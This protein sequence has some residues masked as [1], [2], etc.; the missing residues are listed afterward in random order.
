MKK[1]S[2]NIEKDGNRNIENKRIKKEN[3]KENEGHKKQRKI[4]G[5]TKYKRKHMGLGRRNIK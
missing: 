5:K 3:D 2:Q 4:K 1:E